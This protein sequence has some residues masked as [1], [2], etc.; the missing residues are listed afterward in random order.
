MKK[1]VAVFG[2]AACSNE[3]YY[4]AIARE[5]GKLLAESGFVTVTGAGPGMMDETLRGAH[6]G[7]GQTIG[8]ALAIKE[9][10]KSQFAHEEYVFD[11]LNPRQDKLISLSDAYIALPGGIGTL[12][13]VMA[14]LAMK[15][16]SEI[17]RD[18][19]LILVDNYFL[20]LEHLF[21]KVMAEGF[22]ETSL[23]DL[24]T[25]VKTPTEAVFMLRQHFHN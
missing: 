23:R 24:Y 1:K 17:P 13:E 21:T 10:K 7:N 11:T 9:R 15:R 19:P 8:V 18:T 25:L 6:I 4:Y 2:G 22:V 14:V 16:L 3:A 5:T 12:Y 20:D